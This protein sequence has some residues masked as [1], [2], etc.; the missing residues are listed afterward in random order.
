ME[1]EKKDSEDE[2]V[3]VQKLIGELREYCYVRC[4]H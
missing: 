2:T 4:C 1:R 3:E